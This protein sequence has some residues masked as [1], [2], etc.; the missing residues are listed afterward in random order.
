MTALR[1]SPGRGQTR[2]FPPSSSP[3][4]LPPSPLSTP[5]AP[6]NPLAH[7]SARPCPW[8]RRCGLWAAAASR[9]SGRLRSWSRGGAVVEGGKAAPSRV[10][11]GGQRAPALPLPFLPFPF[12]SP[13][14][15]PPPPPAP[16]PSQG[17]GPALGGC[18]PRREGGK[19]G[20]EGRRGRERGKTE[21]G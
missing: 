2:P 18:E 21:R 19:E 11:A 5:G 17:A 10:P 13:G 4:P 3:W 12:P 9:R 6:L 1:G 15:P 16:R 14:R 20:G 7:P 8:S